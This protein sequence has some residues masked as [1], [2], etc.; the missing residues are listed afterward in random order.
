M[1]ESKKIQLEEENSFE[2]R[3]PEETEME[4]LRDVIRGYGIPA[5]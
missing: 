4:E 5:K 2:S 1:G 3:T